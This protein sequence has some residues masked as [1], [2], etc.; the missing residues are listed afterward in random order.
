MNVPRRTIRILVSLAGLTALTLAVPRSVA[1][2]QSA[3]APTTYASGLTNPRGLAFGPDGKLYV[4]LAGTGGTNATT[5]DQC[6]QV[7]PPIGPDKGG[8]TASIVSVDPSG[9]LSTVASGLPSAQSAM[10]DM[11]GVADVAFIGDTLY[12]LI[13]GGGCSHGNPDA[14]NGVMRIDADGTATLIADLSAFWL[15]NPVA[16]P[17]RAD[18][19]PDGDPYSMVAFQGNLYVVEANHGEVDRVSPDGTITRLADVSAG[20]GHIVPTS[21]AVSGD[22]FLLG[23]LGVFPI[24]PGKEGIFKL[25]TD[26]TLTGIASDFT[27]ILGLA[28]DGQGNTYVLES[29]NAAGMPQ[30]GA[31]DVVRLS[32]SGDRTVIASGLTTPTAIV[33]GPDGALYVSAQGYGAPAGSGAILRVEPPM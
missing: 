9:A 17:N 26:G 16:K 13:T 20:N 25:G 11:F 3:A 22:G 5:A 1:S 10:G 24:V 30:P 12:A 14:P 21:I 18:F 2:A 15:A 27:T 28:V 4:A 6:E 31:G 33:L 7:P 8:S 29:S 32:P 19:E 23:N